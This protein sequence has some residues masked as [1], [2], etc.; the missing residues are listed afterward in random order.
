MGVWAGARDTAAKYVHSGQTEIAATGH[1]RTAQA[2][3]L[4]LA[5]FLLACFS[6]DLWLPQANEG[7][8]V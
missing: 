5:V 1:S 4:P 3:A 7:M 6:L 2:P 8:C